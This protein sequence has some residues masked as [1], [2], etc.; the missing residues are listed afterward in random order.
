MVLD[1]RG[2]VA[3]NA[4]RREAAAVGSARADSSASAQQRLLRRL[5]VEELRIERGRLYEA[6]IRLGRREERLVKAAV[7]Y[8][9]GPEVEEAV[10]ALLVEGRSRRGLRKVLICKQ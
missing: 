6:L 9:D 3:R 10:A 7:V 1:R 4:T 5:L 2:W 8:V